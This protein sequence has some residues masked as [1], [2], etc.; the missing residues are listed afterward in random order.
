MPQAATWNLELLSRAGSMNAGLN[1]IIAQEF[2]D[3]AAVST[4][5]SGTGAVDFMGAYSGGVA[6]MTTGAT[7]GGTA[8]VFS[9]GK[10]S[11]VASALNK[12]WYIHARVQFLAVS[13]ACAAFISLSDS[14]NRDTAVGIFPGGADGK[15]CI[16]LDNTGAG[17]GSNF[18]VSSF[19][20]PLN[21]WIDMDLGFDQPSGTLSAW[22]PGITYPNPVCSTTTLTNLFDSQR[23]LQAYLDNKALAV[24][25]HMLIQRLAIVLEDF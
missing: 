19:Y 1:S 15:I 16:G 12:S 14:S 10:N 23:Y 18:V 24:N 11:I 4:I 6:D 21:S 13:G 8:G 20:A 7:A 22:L 17:G 2:A 5:V 9:A 3:D 25:K